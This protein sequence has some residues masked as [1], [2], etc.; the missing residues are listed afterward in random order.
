MSTAQ[1]PKKTWSRKARGD[2]PVI[3]AAWEAGERPVDLAK[4]FPISPETISN[5]ATKDQWQRAGLNTTRI[6]SKAIAANLIPQVVQQE[7][8]AAIHEEVAKVTHGIPA[9]VR[10]KL[11]EHFAAVIGTATELHKV[12]DRKVKGSLEVEEIKSLSSSLLNVDAIKRRAFGLDGPEG[13]RIS[14]GLLMSTATPSRSIVVEAE[15]IEETGKEPVR[16]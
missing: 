10:A 3:R 5:K 8:K 11:E 1:S 6:A 15:V 13:Q 4:R 2:W 16:Q 7:V 12:I 9:A 14:A